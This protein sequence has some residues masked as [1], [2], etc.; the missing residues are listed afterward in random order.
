MYQSWKPYYT[1]RMLSEPDFRL[2]SQEDKDAVLDNLKRNMVEETTKVSP[3][4]DK[5]DAEEIIKRRLK[6]RQVED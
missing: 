2:L 3:D 4:T 6:R 1:R 5:F